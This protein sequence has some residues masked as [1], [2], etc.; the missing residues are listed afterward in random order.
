MID[1]LLDVLRTHTHDTEGG[2]DTDHGVVEPPWTCV[3]QLF[4]KDLVS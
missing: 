4:G 3:L 1:K 2:D